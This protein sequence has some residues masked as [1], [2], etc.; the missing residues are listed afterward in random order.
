M[1]TPFVHVADGEESGAEMAAV[2]LPHHGFA[3]ETVA[4]DGT[5]STP[6]SPWPR[7]PPPRGQPSDLDG[8][9]VARRLRQIEGA[10]PHGAERADLGARKRVVGAHRLGGLQRAATDD[11]GEAFEHPV[12]V[13]EQQVKAPVGHGTQ[14]LM[15][16]Q[17]GAGAP[18][19]SRNRSSSRSAS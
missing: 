9:A 2:I 1:S 7:A 8:F 19:T 10:G 14:G 18:I 17:R 3:A 4:T 5:P 16:W 6:P 13:V 12:L 15:T 11:H